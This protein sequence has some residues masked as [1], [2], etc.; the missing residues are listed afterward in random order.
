MQA[1]IVKLWNDETLP[2]KDGL[3][4]P[5]GRSLFLSIACAP[6]PVVTTGDWF[7]VSEFHDK[8]KDELA[9]IDTFKE[10]P[11]SSGGILC[12]GGGSYGSEGFIAHLDSQ[13]HLIWA[14]Y[15]ERSNPFIHASENDDGTVIVESSAGFK[16]KIDPADPGRL[17]LY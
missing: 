7:D 13:K 12:I 6:T 8:N 3:Y 17:H 1:T 5:D 10:V 11:L 2:I 15:A 16:L 4:F 9:H 14:L